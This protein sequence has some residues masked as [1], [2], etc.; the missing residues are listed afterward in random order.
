MSS[1]IA[2]LGILPELRSF[3][4]FEGFSDEHIES[5]CKDSTVKITR[6]KEPLLRSKERAEGFYV[7]LSGAYKLTRPA[8][9][10]EDSILHFAHSGDVIGAFIMPQPQP[11]YPISA[12]SMGPSRALRIPRS[13]YIENWKNNGDLIFRIQNL[14]STRM[15]SMQ[16]QR[17]MSKS[18]LQAK[19]ASLL[20]D[21]IEKQPENTD[22]VKIPI[23]LTRKEIADSVGASVESIIRIM[24]DW[25]KKGLIN[26]EDHNITIIKTDK[27]IELMNA[28]Y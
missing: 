27:I 17:V 19:V 21:L 18:P 4:L 26:T 3:R 16:N 24:S 25:S 1:P 22:T 10:G 20:I 8:P 13:N 14:L 7:V 5:L 12:I 6:H 11:V 28:D 23:P 15:T 2:K 9:N